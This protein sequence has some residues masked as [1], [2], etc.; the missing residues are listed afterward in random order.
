MANPESRL[1]LL[2]TSGSFFSSF[3]FGVRSKLDRVYAFCQLELSI[4]LKP[5]TNSVGDSL[6]EITLNSNQTQ[7]IAATITIG[8]RNNCTKN[9]AWGGWTSGNAWVTSGDSDVD[10]TCCFSG[11]SNKDWNS[12]RKRIL[13]SSAGERTKEYEFSVDWAVIPSRWF[14]RLRRFTP[15]HFHLSLT[16]K[17]DSCSC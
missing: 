16:E 7:I 10:V 14:S 12:T 17:S 2:L 3:E 8:I 4:F 11:W 1:T 5:R 6:W 15:Y 9:P 13:L